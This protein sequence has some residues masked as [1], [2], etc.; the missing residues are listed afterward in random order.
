LLLE[1]VVKRQTDEEDAEAN[2]KQL[3]EA[4]TKIKKPSTAKSSI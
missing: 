1:V 2:R 3:S 4:I